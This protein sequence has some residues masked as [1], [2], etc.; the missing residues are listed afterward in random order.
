MK[1]YTVWVRSSAHNSEA[2]FLLN[3]FEEHAKAFLAADAVTRSQGMA[4]VLPRG[5]VES[6]HKHMRNQ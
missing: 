5:L 2:W 1:A 3:S 6:I 4:T